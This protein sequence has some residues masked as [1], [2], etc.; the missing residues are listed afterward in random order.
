MLI[1]TLARILRRSNV[2]LVR[3]LCCFPNVIACIPHIHNVQEMCGIQLRC[4]INLCDKLL[5]I[6]MHSSVPRRC[7]QQDAW[8]PQSVFHADKMFSRIV[9][10]RCWNLLYFRQTCFTPTSTNVEPFFWEILAFLVKLSKIGQ[11]I[12]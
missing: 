8:P 10:N 1:I 3:L 9:S 5:A 11:T 12:T 4:R 7:M 2:H 6:F